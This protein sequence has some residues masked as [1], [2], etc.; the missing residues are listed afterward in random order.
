[1]L[2]TTYF[3]TKYVYYYIVNYNMDKDNVRQEYV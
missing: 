1:M 3:G 2:F